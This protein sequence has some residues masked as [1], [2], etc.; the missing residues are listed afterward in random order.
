MRKGGGAQKQAYR[1][2]R[3]P[4]RTEFSVSPVPVSDSVSRVRRC[5]MNPRQA[6]IVLNAR[7]GFKL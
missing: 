2:S 4:K 3:G 6:L 5:S 7:Q 1:E